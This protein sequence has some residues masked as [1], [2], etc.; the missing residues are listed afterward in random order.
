MCARTSPV[1]PTG[2]ADGVRALEAWSCRYAPVDWAKN[3]NYS[4]GLVSDGRE[5]I[6]ELASDWCEVSS[7][8]AKAN[9]EET[10][11]SGDA[12]AFIVG[13]FAVHPTGL[14]PISYH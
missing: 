9:R 10:D 6:G 12:V 7:K 1:H 8:A 2:R 4:T 5:N 13:T 3:S 11:G 14:Q